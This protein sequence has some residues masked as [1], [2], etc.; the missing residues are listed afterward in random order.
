M[1]QNKYVLEIKFG[2]KIY[3]I[4]RD[5]LLHNLVKFLG[6]LLACVVT[7]AILF[8]WMKDMTIETQECFEANSHLTLR[9]QKAVCT[10]D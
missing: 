9:E 6:V 8:A 1:L 10:W 2:G 4:L 7:F 5:G 3:K